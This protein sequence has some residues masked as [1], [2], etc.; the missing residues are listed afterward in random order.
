MGF[1]TLIED[2]NEEHHAALLGQRFDRSVRLQPLQRPGME[3]SGIAQRLRHL[4][5]A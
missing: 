3:V 4:D 5:E 1:R 2:G